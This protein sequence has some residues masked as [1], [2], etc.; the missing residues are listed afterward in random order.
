MHNE[1]L[2]TIRP[3]PKFQNSM[4]RQFVWSNDE[5]KFP[6]KFPWSLAY[7]KRVSKE[8]Q[9]VQSEGPGYRGWGERRRW[10]GMCLI[11]YQYLHTWNCMKTFTWPNSARWYWYRH[12]KH[13]NAARCR[14]E[15]RPSQA[16]SGSI[17]AWKLYVHKHWIHDRASPKGVKPE[18]G[19]S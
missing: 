3:R 8:P 4:F 7:W 6:A 10:T 16:F 1:S 18:E 5:Y 9:T 17:A 14:Q 11:S 12:P 13:R 19:R 15:C 2:L